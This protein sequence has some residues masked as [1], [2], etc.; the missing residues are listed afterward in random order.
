MIGSVLVSDINW[1]DFVTFW[2]KLPEVAAKFWPPSF[3]NYDATAMIDAMRDTVAIALAATVLT[4]LPSLVL[5]RSPR[6]T[7]PR[8]RVRAASHGSC[9]SASAASLS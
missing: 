3:G 8:A 9:S 2:A 6:A 4:L 7:S 5:A 1:L